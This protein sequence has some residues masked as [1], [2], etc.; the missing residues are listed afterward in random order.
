MIAKVRRKKKF[1]WKEG[2]WIAVPLV[3]HGGWGVGLIARMRAPTIIGYFFG[4]RRSEPPKL[5]ELVS[6]RPEQAVLIASI[7]D[8]GLREKEWLV[9][10]S[11]PDYAR[12]DWPLPEFGRTDFCGFH[13]AV[14]YDDD[15]PLHV[16][17]ERRIS[18]E[19]Y[20]RLPE[21]GSYGSVAL[22][23]E[24]DLTLAKREAPAAA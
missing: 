3:K 10:G 7:S 5:E 2:D 22:S 1:P 13:Y 8:L 4:P 15:E 21:D 18:K 11:Q 14:T 9:L 19:E 6:L 23:I 24:L 12:S 20:Q 17:D 16:L